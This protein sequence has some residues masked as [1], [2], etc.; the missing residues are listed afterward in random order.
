[1]RYL[2]GVLVCGFLMLFT[3]CKDTELE[4]TKAEA[5]KLKAELEQVRTE[6][7]LAKT[8]AETELANAKTRLLEAEKELESTKLASNMVSRPK[9][10]PVENP[11][12][13]WTAEQVMEGYLKSPTIEH[14]LAFVKDPAKV[15]PLMH[16]YYTEAGFGP[17]LEFEIAPPVAH[18][19]SIGTE[20]LLIV[21]RPNLDPSEYDLVRTADGWRVDWEKGV[22]KWKLQEEMSFREAHGLVDA[23]LEVSL[24]KRDVSG[25]AST[26]LTFEFV[27]KSNAT[28]ESATF[29]LYGYDATGKYLERGLMFL[30]RILPSESQI[31]EV[32]LVD[33]SSDQLDS[34]KF[35]MTRLK[36]ETGTNSNEYAEKYFEV[37]EV[38]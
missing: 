11:L 27:N 8:T 24:V 7:E 36:I 18:G 34:W 30:E 20:V 29:E 12:P 32:T 10:S 15:R 38:P 28:I 4:T 33:V 19:S 1:M 3:A 23:C 37:R 2:T 9:I 13:D 6:L 31:E 26:E 22:S 17:I 5:E 35:K 25:S 16:S 21:Q 14:R